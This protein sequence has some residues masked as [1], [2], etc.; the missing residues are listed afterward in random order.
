MKS[1]KRIHPFKNIAARI[2]NHGSN[3][4]KAQKKPSDAIRAAAFVWLFVS[5]LLFLLIVLN[6]L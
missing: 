4:V 3:G 5:L 2:G 6:A 1:K